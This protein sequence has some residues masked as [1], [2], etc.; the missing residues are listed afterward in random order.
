MALFRKIVVD[1]REFEWKF[2]FDDYD[3]MENSHLVFRSGDK[4]LKIMV[5]FRTGGFEAGYCPFNFGVDAI[6]DGQAMSINLNQPRFAAEIL[7]YVLNSR[8]GTAAQGIFP[9]R[10]G[11]QILKELGY[12]FEYHL[13]PKC[14]TQC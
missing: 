5:Y 9:Y 6:K 7:R 4:R 1:E 11:I 8:T 14:P 12:D 13:L 2:T 3:M 10:D